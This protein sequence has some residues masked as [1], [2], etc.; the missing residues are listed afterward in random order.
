MVLSK[1]PHS[2]LCVMF[3]HS[4]GSHHMSIRALGNLVMIQIS[5]YVA[6]GRGE[7][8]MLEVGGGSGGGGGGGGWGHSVHQ[9]DL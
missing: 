1:N 7:Q 9:S 2:L 6:W 8:R 5:K 4:K 3:Q